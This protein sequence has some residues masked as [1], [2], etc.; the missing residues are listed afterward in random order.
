MKQENGYIVY[1]GPSVLDGAP[2]VVIATMSSTNVQTGPKGRKNMVQTWILRADIDP[3]TGAREGADSSVCG[4]CPHR[5]IAGGA[6][7]VTLF[8]APLAVYRTYRAG[9]YSRDT[10]GFYMALR[11][12]LIRMGAYGD[13]AAVPLGVWKEIVPKALGHTGYTHQAKHPR[14]QKGLLDYVMES[15]DS[16]ED[17]GPNRYFR[18]KR[19][20]DPALVG[21]VECLA[22]SRGLTCAECLLCDGNGRGKGKSVFINVHGA[23]ATK[24]IP[25]PSTPRAL[26]DIIAI[27]A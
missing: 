21:E 1:E 9:G 6:C 7:Y 5:P 8:Q 14:F 2:I 26:G 18:V 16:P 13:P 23:K 4:A 19:P 24:F 25:T 22:D 15:I 20:E 10:E 27:A 17:I 12:R 11:G 3:V